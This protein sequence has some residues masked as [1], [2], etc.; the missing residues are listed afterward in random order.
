MGVM[1]GYPKK[2]YRD[3]ERDPGKGPTPLSYENK[4]GPNKNYAPPGGTN[5]VEKIRT[6]KIPNKKG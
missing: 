2:G 5:T 1:K 6:S 4:K 3:F